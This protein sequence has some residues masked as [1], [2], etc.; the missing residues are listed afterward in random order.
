MSEKIDSSA[1]YFLT[2]IVIGATISLFFAPKSGEG[3]R[4]YLS[5]K[6]NEA[7]S[8]LGR[9][10]GNCGSTQMTWSSAA[11]NW[12]TRPKNKLLRN[13]MRLERPTRRRNRRLKAFRFGRLMDCGFESDYTFS[14]PE[15]SFRRDLRRIS[16][17]TEIAPNRAEFEIPRFNLNRFVAKDASRSPTY[18]C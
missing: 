15:K 18:R 4:K 1:G 8:T 17:E 13:W 2:G 16:L 3:T 14:A 5:K 12:L 7:R 9:R 10:R 6:L 11:R